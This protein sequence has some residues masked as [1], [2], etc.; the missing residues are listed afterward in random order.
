MT[1]KGV[2]RDA[3]PLFTGPGGFAGVRCTPMFSVS[4]EKAARED[5]RVLIRL[6]CRVGAKMVEAVVGGNEMETTHRTNITAV[7]VRFQCSARKNNE[8]SSVQRRDWA[9]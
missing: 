5:L 2:A 3:A 6:L 8:I 4:S 1:V 9:C 7:L